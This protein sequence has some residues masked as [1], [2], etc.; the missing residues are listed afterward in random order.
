MIQKNIR[1]VKILNAEF[2]NGKVHYIRVS[3]DSWNPAW[4]TTDYTVEGGKEFS[5]INKMGQHCGATFEE[6]E[7]IKQAYERALK[8]DFS[9]FQI[10]DKE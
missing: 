7:L 5:I 8:L 10:Q 1:E 3:I 9:N 2:Q 6:I 4:G